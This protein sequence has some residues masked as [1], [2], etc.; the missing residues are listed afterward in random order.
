M[1]QQFKPHILIIDDE[2]SVCLS[3]QGILEDEGFHVDTALSGEDGIR[4][5]ATEQ[6]DL[7]FLDILMPGGID[8]IET[9]RRIKQLAQDTEVIMITG[10]GSFELAMEAGLLG[11]FGFLGK[12]LSLDTVLEH[13]ERIMQKVALRR[14]QSAVGGLA[15]PIIGNS[16]AIQEVLMTIRRVAPTTGRVLV[17]GESGT[18]KEL[19]AHAVHE[20]SPRRKAPFVRV[21]CAAI[22]KDLIEAELLGHERGAF[23]GATQ[24][25]IGKFEQADGGTIF[26]DEIADMSASAQAKALRVIEEGEFER[27]GGTHT[28]HVNV[29]VISATNKNLQREIEN[30]NFREDLYYRLNVIPIHLPPLRERIEDVVPIADY[31]LER[32][33][34]ENNRAKMAFSKAAL[35]ALRNYQWPGNVREIRNLIERLTILCPSQT[36]DVTD[37][38]PEFHSAGRSA[39]ATQT[40]LRAAR[41]QFESRFIRNCLD[42]NNWNITETAKQLGIE[43][44]NL[45]RKMRQYEIT[46]DGS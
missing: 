35:Q 37:L 5:L 24:R 3:L 25:R 36:I 44:T 26:L 42:M 4:L 2:R 32:F 31:F 45:H 40:D 29:R 8:G 41:N 13:V 22:P 21:N 10:H 19:I 43:R 46:R 18:G 20:L 6:I 15:R 14:N 39:V 23:T 11:A 38:P 16:A 7:V 33:C 12:P 28:V 17:T 9:L 1:Q 30:D 27:V 34:Q